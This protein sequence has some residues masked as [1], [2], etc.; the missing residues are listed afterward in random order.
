MKPLLKPLAALIVALFA[1]NASAAQYVYRHAA[2]NINPAPAGAPFSAPTADSGLPGAPADQSPVANDD[3]FSIFWSGVYLDLA[4]NDSDP[5]GNL[6]RGSIVITTP[7][8]EGS[9]DLILPS[10]EVRYNFPHGSAPVDSFGYTI[11]D[12]AGNV[13][14]EA[15]VNISIGSVGTAF[16]N[17]PD[18]AGGVGLEQAADNI[19]ALSRPASIRPT[20]T[21]MTTGKWYWETSFL[22]GNI[23]YSTG[24]APADASDY[25]ATGSLKG[26]YTYTDQSA[27]VTRVG[28]AFDADT[29]QLRI[30]VRDANGDREV[31]SC[32]S[33]EFSVPASAAG[34]LPA[35][36]N[37][38]SGSGT[39]T[40]QYGLAEPE[41]QLKSSFPWLADYQPLANL[42]P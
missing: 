21:L 39:T 38:D 7:P 13:S 11:A 14:N 33:C 30:V 37:S 28:Y 10:G 25:S 15:L 17:M 6:A 36:S 1:A 2:D 12:G 8:S 41:F 29:Q 40:L 20:Q 22:G 19:V 26:Y 32:Y 35:A 5:E 9:I 18:V 31:T 3:S 34:Y 42:L 4:A 23:Y 27:V 24:V 16:F